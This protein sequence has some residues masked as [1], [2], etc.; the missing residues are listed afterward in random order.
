MAG[1]FFWREVTDAPGLNDARRYMT[2]LDQLARPLD[3]ERLD[4]IVEGWHRYIDRRRAVL[5]PLL[6]FHRLSTTVL[7]LVFML[8]FARRVGAW[9]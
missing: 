9:R 3:G 2:G 1:D 6:E 8:A 7:A 5:F 4:L